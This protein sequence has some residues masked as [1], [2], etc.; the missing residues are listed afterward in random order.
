MKKLKIV[1]TVFMV[2][3]MV[4]FAASCQPKPTSQLVTSKAPLD[5]MQWR[6]TTAKGWDY[7][8]TMPPCPYVA[9][10]E[11]TFPMGQKLPIGGAFGYPH[12]VITNFC[13]LTEDFYWVLAEK[14]TYADVSSLDPSPI[15]SGGKWFPS[16]TPK[17]Y[18]PSKHPT[19]WVRYRVALR[20]W[21]YPTFP[22][23]RWYYYNIKLII[24]NEIQ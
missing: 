1:L 13:N 24:T 2:A 10:Q 19:A 6:D 23:G 15:N 5:T 21:D 14:S 18:Q 4:L 12:I 17:I 22:C 16:G 7:C 20:R 3:L 9:Y 11:F 8:S